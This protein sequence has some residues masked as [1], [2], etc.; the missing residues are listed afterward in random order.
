MG[1]RV[2]G[3]AST[4]LRTTWRCTWLLAGTSTT[5]LPWICAEQDSRCPASSG[6]R[7][8]KLCS[9]ALRGERLAACELTPCLGKSPSITSTWQRPHSARPPHTESTST[10]RLRAACRSG[11]P[12]AKRPRLPEG[13]KTTSASLSL[14]TSASGIPWRSR[15]SLDAPAVP[16]LAPAARCGR[17]RVSR[18][19]GCARG[20]Q[21]RRLPEAADPARAIRVVAHH[22][23]RRHARPDDL[24][25]HRV[26]DR[27][28]E[29]GADRHGEEG[30]R[31]A[32]TRREPEAHVRGAAG[33][34]HLE[35]V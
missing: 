7:R 11:V 33:G 3:C 18:G 17:A 6:R 29:A 26:H 24:E 21:R 9:A 2:I 19:R 10:P 35:L 8:E 27:G 1:S 14:M 4:A 31:D 34:V 5:R 12:S 22:H 23:I 15:G 16:A 28:S 25:V 30:G 20:L 13:V 32:L